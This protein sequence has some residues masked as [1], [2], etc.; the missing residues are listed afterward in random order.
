M[1]NVN[2]AVER[3]RFPTPTVDDV[4]FRLK[5]A[6]YFTKLDLNAAFH[7]L[8]LDKR[9]RYITAFQTE[10]RI[11]RFKRLTFGLS[12]VSE[13]L[14]HYLQTL[15]GDISDLINIAGDILIFAPTIAEHDLILQKV[16]QRLS[17]KGLTLNLDKC[18]FQ[19]KLWNILVLLFRKTV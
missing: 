14:Q 9:S 2:T 15:L 8:Q 10:D 13:Q 19:K 11:K 7:Q 5:N 18:L 4:I 3:T 6:Q 17:K 16:F 1:R 12:S